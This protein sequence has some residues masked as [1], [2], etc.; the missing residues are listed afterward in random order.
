[1]PAFTSESTAAIASMATD[2]EA[3][4]AN[5]HETVVYFP[6]ADNPELCADFRPQNQVSIF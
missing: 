1:M 4:V 2:R 5:N 3:G 6:A